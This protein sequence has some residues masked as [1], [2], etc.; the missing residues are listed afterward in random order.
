MSTEV[1]LATS[2]YATWIVLTS[3]PTIPAAVGQADFASKHL[4]EYSA[5]LHAGVETEQA[6]RCVGGIGLDD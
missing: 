3:Q 5:Q 2:L 6:G 4:S 1:S